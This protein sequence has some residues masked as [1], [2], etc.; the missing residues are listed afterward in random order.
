MIQLQLI[1]KIL[2]SKSI[3]IVENNL[4]SKECFVGYEEEF[5]YIMDHVRQY[6]NVPDTA[7]FLEAFPETELVEVNESDAYLVDK[8]REEV[9]WRKVVPV[10]QEAAKIA[11]TDANKAAEYMMSTIKDLQPDYR[12]GGT[13]IIA[14]ASQRF[15]QF[16]DRKT[17]QD[18]WFFTCGFPE[19]DDL[20]HGIQRTEE[21]ILIVARVHQGKSWTLE[22]ICT[23]IWQIG[24]N[25]GYVSPE[26]SASSVGYRF[27]TLH[28][29]FSNTGLMWGKDEISEEDY[30][31]Y[32][33][34]LSKRENKFIV[35]T[36][37]DFDRKITISKL[38]KWVK[39]YKL[40]AIAIDGI[41][42][43][44]D[45]RNKRGDTKTTSL[46]NISEDLMSLSIEL[47]IPILVVA[48]ANR[49]G[50]KKDED[51]DDTPD[52]ENVRDSDGIAFNASK[53]LSIRQ[54]T[55]GVLTMQIKKQRN[56]KVGGKLKYKWNIDTGEYEFIPSFDD[57][58]PKEK[59]E[60]K[61]QDMKK[62]YQD[63]KEVF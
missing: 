6:G 16:V 35:A 59:T 9:L 2:D 37:L 1:S 26:M 18:K 48:Q 28:K 10:I 46:T 30:S 54:T 55:E 63:A 19:L 14:Q 22:K 17:H 41:T 33:E 11:E 50:V 47:N 38:R 42:Y 29:N 20:W 62:K 44:S 5:D 60:R 8:A 15:D 34:D 40:D 24:Y 3:D 56:G 52:L 21:F 12:L 13:N 39:Q 7:T 31:K 61:V 23:H 43:L 36:P 27:D 53:V 45:E 49:E 25:V 58:E 32:I 51:N 57:A 4:L